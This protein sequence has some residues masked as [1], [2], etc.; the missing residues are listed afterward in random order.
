MI[1]LM[2]ITLM[3]LA[4]IAVAVG[5]VFLK[6]AAL[7]GGFT[8]AMASPW[9][10]AAIVL[11]LYQILFF[12]YAFLTGWQ[13]SVIG[14]MQT[15]LYALIVLGAGVMYFNESLSIGQGIGVLMAF[16]GVVLMNMDA[17]P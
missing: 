1:K 13:L 16:T 15:V 14:S 7:E 12:T 3:V 11:Y 5:D 10:A 9:M 8:R 2:H 6:K 4:V 17:Y